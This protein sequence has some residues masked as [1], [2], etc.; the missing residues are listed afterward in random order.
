VA[1]KKVVWNQ[2]DNQDNFA[3]RTECQVA[4]GETIFVPV[5]S[6]RRVPV[7][8]KTDKP[9]PVKT[10]PVTILVA[11][12]QTITPR[13]GDQVALANHNAAP[14]NKDLQWD[15]A[16]LR[17]YRGQ[18]DKN[19]VNKAISLRQRMVDSRLFDADSIIIEKPST[20][21]EFLDAMMRDSKDRPIK[22][23]VFFGHS[24]PYGFYM[25][26]DSACYVDYSAFPE[27]KPSAEART[28]KSDFDACVQNK[29][30]K[31]A[32]DALVLFCGCK[33]AGDTSVDPYSLGHWFTVI[34]GATTI[35][36]VGG[37]DQ[38]KAPSFKVESAHWF[39]GIFT[40]KE[41]NGRKLT[42]T[43][44]QSTDELVLDPL[45]ILHR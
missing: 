30:I 17:W 9:N 41:P 3:G 33:A 42:M 12:Q 4:P 27:M 31:F 35:G 16:K 11:A 21:L 18:E 8:P 22:N 7:A 6:V 25:R 29:T 37:S 34:T 38:S 44:M 1:L 19:F 45:K 23:L 39:W 36:S 40:K 32:D 2:P 14:A 20:G 15:L 28:I 13:S 5:R 10:Q 24:G 26:E 43:E